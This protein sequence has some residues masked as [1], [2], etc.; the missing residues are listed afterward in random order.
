MR[1][2]C[3]TV[4]RADPLVLAVPV[5]LVEAFQP[6]PAWLASPRHQS[7][8][9]NDELGPEVI[10]R[11]TVLKWWRGWLAEGNE[12]LQDRSSRAIK[13]LRP[14]PYRPQRNGEVER[15]NRTLA[16]EFLCSSTFRSENERRRPLDLWV[17][18]YNH[19]RN[20][21]AVGGPHLSRVHNACG[22]YN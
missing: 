9:V 5:V 16:D 14:R 15:F 22:S 6:A 18:G 3:P 7:C 10:R 13:H 2:V 21:S 4:H 19:H 1:S 17:H 11:A 20:H 12:G 8:G